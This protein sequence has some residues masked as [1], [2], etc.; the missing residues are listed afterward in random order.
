MNGFARQILV[1]FIAISVFTASSHE[2]FGGSVIPREWRGSYKLSSGRLSSTSGDSSSLDDRTVVLGDDYVAA[3]VDGVP[4]KDSGLIVDRIAIPASGF[5]K[6]SSKDKKIFGKM[7]DVLDEHLAEF[8]K[9][10]PDVKILFDNVKANPRSEVLLIGR[11]N[12]A[13]GN[14]NVCTLIAWVDGETQWIE[15]IIVKNANITRVISTVSS[16]SRGSSA[17]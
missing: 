14:V 4:Q 5:S 2:G 15:I 11:P 1:L 16:A 6:L 8:R 9:L 3:V 17:N 13:L 12:R 7:K 10:N